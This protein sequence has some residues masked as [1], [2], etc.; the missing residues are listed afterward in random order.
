VIGVFVA[1][2]NGIELVRSGAR[3]LEP[4][5]QL[6]GAQACIHKDSG[7]GRTD[8]DR[9]SLRT[10][11]QNLKEESHQLSLTHYPLSAFTRWGMV[12]WF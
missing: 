3:L 8:Q 10:A 1:D 2:D 11:G 12:T 9:I 4:R 6:F 7:L 5:V